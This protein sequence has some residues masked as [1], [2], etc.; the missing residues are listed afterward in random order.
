MKL[1]LTLVAC[2]ATAMCAFAGPRQD[3]MSVNEVNAVLFNGLFSAERAVAEAHWNKLSR[4]EKDVLM[5]RVS[6][7]MA[8]SHKE[9]M[10]MKSAPSNA[11]VWEHMTSGL[12]ADEAATMGRIARGMNSAEI[13]VG[14][15]IV[16]NACMYGVAHAK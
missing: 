12:T 14:M 6:L 5:K 11:Q 10:A 9:L 16:H 15:R 13:A 7:C 4:A 8:D 1:T 3:G 2:L